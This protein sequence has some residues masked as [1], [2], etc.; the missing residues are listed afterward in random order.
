MDD[1]NVGETGVDSIRLGGYKVE[2]LRIPLESIK[3]GEQIPQAIETER[4]SRVAN[5][6][7]K[8]P[9][10]SISF[11]QSQIGVCRKHIVTMKQ[12]ISGWQDEIATYKVLVNECKKRDELLDAC[13]VPE[14]AAHIRKE[15][16]PYS[17][18]AM[19]AQ[20]VQFQESIDQAEGVIEKE[21]TSIEE[22]QERIGLCKERDRQLRELGESV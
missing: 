2:N 13:D 11:L 15:Y 22:V 19:E 18:K 6:R 8:F 21:H 16:K 20:L 1:T 14:V 7:A 9:E 10:Q 17:V 3:A 5:V 12:M 4:K